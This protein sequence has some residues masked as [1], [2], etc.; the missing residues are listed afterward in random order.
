MPDGSGN[1][2]HRSDVGPPRGNS[3]AIAGVVLDESDIGLLFFLALED[4]DS[5]LRFGHFG[6][7]RGS[8][9]AQDRAARTRAAPEFW[10][11]P[12]VDPSGWAI[13]LRVRVLT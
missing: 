1:L 5:Y 12:R 2:V 3:R 4:E 11:F 7:S 8:G 6:T 10:R 13:V 9:H